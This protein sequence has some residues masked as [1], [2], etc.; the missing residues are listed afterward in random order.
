MVAYRSDNPAAN[1]GRIALRY[2]RQDPATGALGLGL[3]ETLTAKLAEAS[4]SD[5]IQVVSPRDLRDQGVKTA[6][7]ARREFGTDLVLESSL[8]RSGQTIR[9]N[10][11]LVDS[12][13]HR[14]IAARSITVDAG[15]TFGLQDQV[16]SETLDMLPVQIKAE[17]RRKLNVSQDTQPAAYEAYIRGRGYMQEIGSENIDKAIAEFT[18]AIHI[19]PNYALGYACLGIVIGWD[20]SSTRNQTAGSRTPPAIAKRHC[21]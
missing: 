4:A 7:D 16:V 8:Q 2:R 17:Q 20:F 19:D 12:K 3:T 9:V 6:A 15:D 10:C 11:F 21:R 1:F 14:Q 18:K 5:G 13:T